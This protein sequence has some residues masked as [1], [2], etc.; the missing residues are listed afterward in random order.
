M[1]FD[2]QE[3]EMLNDLLFQANDLEESLTEGLDYILKAINHP[4]GLIYTALPHQTNCWIKHDLSEVWQDDLSRPDSFLSAVLRETLE[5]GRAYHQANPNLV[6]AVL[7]ISAGGK[8]L[9]ALAV[10]GTPAG[11]EDV[12]RWQVYTHPLARFLTTQR[13]INELAGQ[14]HD[15]MA[16]NLLTAAQNTNL[17][18]NEIQLVIARGIKEIYAADCVVL[19][20][21]DNEN[22]ALAIRKTMVDY[23][24]WAAQ[25]SVTVRP[26]PVLESITRGE[27]VE[28]LQPEENSAGEPARQI[29]APLIANGQTYGAVQVLGLQKSPLDPFALSLLLS[30]STALANAL[31]NRQLFQRLSVINGDLE[32]SRWEILNSRN[33]L[34]TLFDS[35]PASIYIIDRQYSLVAINLSRAAKAGS[36]P[37][38]VVGRKCYE[39]L[40]HLDRPCPGCR[41]HETFEEGSSTERVWVD[42]SA[43]EWE[44]SSFPITDDQT[45]RPA[46]AILLEQDVTEKHRLEANLVQSEKLAAIGQLAAGVAHEINNPLAAIVANAQLVQ[47]TFGEDDDPFIKESIELILLAGTRASQVVRSLLLFARKEQLESEPFDMN[48]NLMCAVSLLQ[49]EITSRPVSLE[50]DLSRDL[51]RFIGNKDQIQRVWVNILMNA[52][53]AT[54]KGI[55]KIKI[56][57]RLVEGVFQVSISDT[58]QGIPPEQISHIF[59]PFFTTKAPGSGTGLGLSVCYRII[60][61]Y[62][63]KIDV[64]SRVDQG[65]CFTVTLPSQPGWLEA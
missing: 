25:E 19:Y 30:L 64:D 50:L 24:D 32:A 3:I 2:W 26:G 8:V 46:R 52:M 6:A 29:C 13:R 35:I 27:A 61:E 12:R 60:S 38:R 5:T 20:L 65:T 10:G 39:T 28:V 1:N 43:Q 36:R 17:D 21:L 15:L 4:F 18:I 62:G 14:Q 49:H 55:N 7:P 34:R 23:Q 56:A 44:I 11:K 31:L 41:V 48:E 47:R 37:N 59:E 22:S 40:F 33:T 54:G 57:T 42:A 45:S 16:M 51:P 53:Q 9:G 58:G 63:G